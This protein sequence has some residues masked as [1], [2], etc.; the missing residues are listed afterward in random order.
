MHSPPHSRTKHQDLLSI[1]Y[2]YLVGDLLV[3]TSSYPGQEPTCLNT[4]K[5]AATAL[6]VPSNI[7][8]K[9]FSVRI[10]RDLS[11]RSNWV[12]QK[13]RHS[14]SRLLQTSFDWWCWQILCLSR[15][16]KYFTVITF[17]SDARARAWSPPRSARFK[18]DKYSNLSSPPPGLYNQGDQKDGSYILSTFRTTGITK[19]HPE[20]SQRSKTQMAAGREGIQNSKLTGELNVI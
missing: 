16:V 17:Y 3:A 6:G 11:I 10:S 20:K 14:W 12:V 8:S 2:T 19:I 7:G 9:I 13:E 5:W 1:R 4:N 15:P 18:I